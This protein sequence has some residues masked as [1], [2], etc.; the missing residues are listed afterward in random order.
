MLEGHGDY[1]KLVR[2]HNFSPPQSN[3]LLMQ[4]FYCRKKVGSSPNEYGNLSHEQDVNSKKDWYI[5]SSSE[6]APRGG[7][8]MDWF[9][10]IENGNLSIGGV[11]L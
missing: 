7:V 2:M 3:T 9:I 5:S 4:L 1:F 10:A 8:P 11:L 6:E